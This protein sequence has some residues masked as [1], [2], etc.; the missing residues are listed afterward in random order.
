M[1]Y[2]SRVRMNPLRE[3]SRKLLVNPR[4]VHAAVL[5]G[6]PDPT[7]DER[8]LWRLDNDDAHRP[9]LFVLTRSRPDWSHLVEQI[10]WPDADGEHAAVRDYAPLLAQVA[11][12]R[13]FAFRLNA[14]PVQ[15]T[16]TPD[17]PTTAQAKLLAERAKAGEKRGR[18]FRLAHR[19]AAAQLNWF[20]SRA[21]RWGFEVPGVR[22]DPAAPGMGDLTRPEGAPEEAQ[23]RW[24][25]NPPY[26][27]R[28]TARN[29]HS[30]QKNP[31]GALVVFHSATFEGRLLITDTELFKAS[32]LGGIGPSK[33]YGCGLL[34]LA[35]LPK[36]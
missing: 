22:T 14:N 32:L 33:A 12:G 28:I 35:P 19:T 6:L 36:G 4:A 20:L 3:A 17:K 26:E 27:V 25:P 10:G 7:A 31:Q 11:V 18:G 15:N 34:T 30:V 21:A 16:Q 23:P 5:G 24:D 29:R 2:L 1:T 9:H 13:E 8:L